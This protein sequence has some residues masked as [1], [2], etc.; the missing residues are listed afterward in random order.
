MAEYADREH[1][2]PLRRTDLVKLLT[3]D[4]GLSSVEREQVRQFCTL[5]SA[6][7]HFEYQKQL[8][9]LKDA[10]APFDPD[11]D[12]KPLEPSRA[13]D[14]PPQLEALFDKFTALMERA[15]FKRL[16][17]EDILK[18]TEA[19]SEPFGINMDVDMNVFERLEVF[20][21]GDTTI[22]RVRRPWWKLWTREE[23]VIPA[24][25]RLVMILKLRR[26]RRLDA[27]I[28]TD[29]VFLKVFKE[30][31]KMDLDTLLP[32]AKV[33]LTKLDQG[34]IIYPLAAGAGLIL[35]NV[36]RDLGADMW[37]AVFSTAAATALI[38][39]A[40]AKIASWTMAA[41]FGG[42][43]YKSYYSFQIKKQTYTLRLTRN[44]YYQSLD[45]NAGVLMR[46]LDEAEE[47]EC[48]EVYLA[49][50]C[51]WRY[52]PPGGWTAPQLDDYVEIELERRANLKVDFEIGDALAK[53]ERLGIVQKTGECYR[54]VPIER[55][56]EVL[57]YA[58]D[59]YFK[60]N[61]PETVP[62]GVRPNP[63]PQKGLR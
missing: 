1:Y 8:E 59:N 25:G 24:Y 32:G 9:A 43:G 55:A 14:R 3:A 52:A 16:S 10:Y 23:R 37:K 22:R 18:A 12:T 2:I 5:T 60:Y 63:L 6:V 58:W 17:R 46:L 49:Y 53:L 47:Q 50:F 15:N 26:H 20:S 39:G 34:L 57:D 28:D 38:A 30:I 19:A 11:A 36:I 51:L 13:D 21:R 7:F 61:N 27:D 29:A 35:W 48:R 4:K 45:N 31:P 44:L 42:Y 40:A 33:Q 56:L 62:P 41:A 54:A